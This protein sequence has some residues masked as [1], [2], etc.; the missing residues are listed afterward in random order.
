MNK[1]KDM[2][3]V[4]EPSLYRSLAL[5]DPLAMTRAR[6]AFYLG[7]GLETIRLHVRGG[8]YAAR[9]DEAV[10]LATWLGMTSEDVIVMKEY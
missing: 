8:T 7:I 2:R 3:I 4:I 6:A 9:A 1:T 5:E 10:E